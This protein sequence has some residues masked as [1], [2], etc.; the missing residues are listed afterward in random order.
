MKNP[1]IRSTLRDE[2]HDMTYHVLAYRK[3][4][5]LEMIETVK[6]YLAQPKI[7][8]RQT[9]ERNKIVTTHAL[10]GSELILALA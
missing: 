10:L 5:E 1:D 4:T 3:L 8:R 9:P 7:L 6:L 2:E